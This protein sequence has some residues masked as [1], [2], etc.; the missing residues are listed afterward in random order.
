[1]LG[2][3]HRRYPVFHIAGTNGK[4]STVA[5]LDALLRGSGLRVGRYTSPH[6]VDF[7]ERVVVNGVP[8][9]REAIT[10]WLETWEPELV[11]LGATFFEATTAMAFSHLAAAKVDV[12]IVEVGL[13]GRLDATNVVRPLVAAV[14]QIGLD[15]TEYL[16]DTLDAIAGE[17]AGIFKAGV[18][19]IVGD[20]RSEIRD[21]LVARA[22]A[23]GA[24][25]ILVTGRDWTVSDVH[26][27]AAET[28]FTLHVGARARQLRRR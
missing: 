19:A 6:L 1:M 5:T 9:P 21:L 24:A 27:G 13:G 22:T 12:A 25:P 18:A 15:H 23:V 7:S 17:K 16:G 26:V 2:D 4:G 11:R 10:E 8:M 14:T 20:T 3:P 28:R